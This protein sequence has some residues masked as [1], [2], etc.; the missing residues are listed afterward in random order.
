M[1]ILTSDRL[2]FAKLV[3]R[4][5]EEFEEAPGLELDVEEGAR[6]WALERGTCALVLSR[7]HDLKFLV[8]TIDGRYRRS[9]AV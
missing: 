9:S 1:G 4:I 8:R 3:Q 7:L 5:R 2:R 6:F